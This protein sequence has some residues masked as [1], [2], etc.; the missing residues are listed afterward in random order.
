MCMY[1][2]ASNVECIIKYTTPRSH[3]YGYRDYFAREFNNDIVGTGLSNLWAW[4]GQ[5]PTP[6]QHVF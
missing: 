6:I 3:G 2:H 5:D 4:L 1:M